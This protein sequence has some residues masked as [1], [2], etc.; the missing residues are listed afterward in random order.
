MHG[1]EDFVDIVRREAPFRFARE[2]ELLELLEELPRLVDE[3]FY[4]RLVFRHRASLL[5]TYH[6]DFLVI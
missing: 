6:T 5:T 1:A 3:D 4:H 2:R